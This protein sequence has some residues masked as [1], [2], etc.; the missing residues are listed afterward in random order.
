MIS[1]CESERSAGGFRRTVI[2]PVFGD[3]WPPK[4]AI[5]SVAST[6]GSCSRMSRAMWSSMLCVAARLVPCGARKETWKED[7]SS[8]GR[9]LMPASLNIG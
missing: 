7:S 3:A 2:E 9:K 8:S 4:P 5:A 1:A 6:P